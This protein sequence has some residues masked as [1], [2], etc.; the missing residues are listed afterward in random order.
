MVDA[1]II[2]LFVLIYRA[3]SAV[4]LAGLRV[5]LKRGFRRPY[6]HCFFG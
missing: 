2:P 6:V 5:G 3:A 4:A 1:G